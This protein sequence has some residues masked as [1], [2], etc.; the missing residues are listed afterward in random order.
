MEAI[1]K[2]DTGASIDTWTRKTVV[3]GHLTF[4][5][6]K[7]FGTVAGVVIEHVLE[8]RIQLQQIT[9]VVQLVRDQLIVL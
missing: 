9:T 7:T 3:N 8:V 2:V 5:S 4:P 6:K 1:S